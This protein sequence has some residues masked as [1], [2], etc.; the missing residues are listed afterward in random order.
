MKVLLSIRWPVGGIRTY[1]RYIYSQP[2]FHNMELTIVAPDREL[3]D[4]ID[5]YIQGPKIS[6]VPV[7]DSNKALVKEVRKQLKNS[8]YQLLH[9]HGFSAGVL[10]EIAKIGLNLPH[11]MTAHDMLLKK[12]FTGVKG[13]LKQFL[14]GFL[15]RRITAIHTIT[16]DAKNNLLTFFPK[17]NEK[18][19]YIIMHG[20]DTKF[21]LEEKPLNKE[22]LL[23]VDNSYPLIGF[24][25]RFMAPKGFRDLVDAMYL[26]IQSRALD[27]PPKVMTFGGGGFVREDYEYLKSLGL[28]SY[29]LQ[30]PFQDNM[31]AAIKAMDLIV[32][33]SRWEA[34]GLLAM[35]TLA[36]GVPIIG[37]NC[38]GLREVLDGT[39]A[40][41]VEAGNAKKLADAI[42]HCMK[43]PKFELFKSYQAE[44][45]DR[46]SVDHP[47]KSLESLYG[48]LI[49]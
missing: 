31:A 8:K 19:V 5:K 47:A 32:M 40:K 49:T 1:L 39:P 28:A 42:I 43:E 12:Q 11:L 35:E 24:F 38:V 13:R 21:F 23:G 41:V 27:L 37:S 46:F 33:P 34:C 10:S 26:V 45:V 7:E 29:F 25:G 4:F 9:S 48:R 16:N 14:I 30:M 6:F 3:S 44:A 20:V 18:C 15:Y 2:C 22:D 36:A 17:I